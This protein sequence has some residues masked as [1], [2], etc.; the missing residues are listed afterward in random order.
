MTKVRHY[1]FLQKQFKVS[2][3][4]NDFVQTKWRWFF[5]WETKTVKESRAFLPLYTEQ[6]LRHK[7]SKS[8]YQLVLRRT[9]RVCFH[10][11]LNWPWEFPKQKMTINDPS[12][13]SSTGLWYIMKALIVDSWYIYIIILVLFTFPPS[14][15]SSP[16]YSF[17]VQKVYLPDSYQLF[18]CSN[19]FGFFILEKLY[20]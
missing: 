15:S 3:T 19:Y 18:C 17:H 10:L 20:I 12:F 4:S 5:F 2:W 16:M 11:S 1:F 13:F 6:Y 7:I 14:P 9:H 8:Y